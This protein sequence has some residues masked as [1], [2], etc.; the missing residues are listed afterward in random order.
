MIFYQLYY[1]IHIQQLNFSFKQNDKFNFIKLLPMNNLFKN[2][3]LIDKIIY[4]QLI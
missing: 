2:K 3:T 4:E 1:L